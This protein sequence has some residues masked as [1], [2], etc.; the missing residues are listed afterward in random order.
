[1]V[2]LFS[3]G[4]PI[5]SVPLNSSTSPLVQ[6]SKPLDIILCASMVKSTTD[7]TDSFIHS[8][9]VSLEAQNWNKLGGAGQ[10]T[11]GT[12]QSQSVSITDAFWKPLESVSV[13]T[14]FSVHCLRLLCGGQRFVSVQCDSPVCP[15]GEARCADWQFVLRHSDQWKVQRWNTLQNVNNQRRHRLLSCFTKR[16]RHVGEYPPTLKS[17]GDV[18]INFVQLRSIARCRPLS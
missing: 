15:T 5:P 17:R 14:S 13:T 9:T 11:S 10:V 6:R 2:I 16:D 8:V 12:L 7:C 18:D 1:M 3:A 4:P